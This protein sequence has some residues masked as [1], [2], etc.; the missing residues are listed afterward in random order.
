MGGFFPLAPTTLDTFAIICT[1]NIVLV[2]CTN[3]DLLKKKKKYIL[4]Y[5]KAYVFNY[6]NGAY[7]KIL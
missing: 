3:K 5:T 6:P 7:A 4:I 2:D 1:H